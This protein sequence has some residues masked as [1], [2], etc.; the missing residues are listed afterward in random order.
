MDKQKVIE[1]KNVKQ[2]KDFEVGEEVF[3]FARGEEPIRGIIINKTEWKGE[4][5]F[6]VQSSSNTKTKWGSK[7][8]LK[9]IKKETDEEV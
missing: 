3:Y 8:Q 4:T 1:K 7:T 6:E 5:I 2:I 9:R